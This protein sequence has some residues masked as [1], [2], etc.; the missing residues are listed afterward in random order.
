MLVFLGQ[1]TLQISVA[2]HLVCARARPD[3]RGNAGLSATP[4][5]KPRGILAAV[6]RS[7]EE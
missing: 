1:A 6:L 2:V 7:G 3:S 4:E 5:C